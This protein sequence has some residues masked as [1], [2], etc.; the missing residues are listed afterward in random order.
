MPSEPT[1]Q[2]PRE[3]VVLGL[4]RLLP[5]PIHEDPLA[6]LSPCASQAREYREYAGDV[7]L[8][9]SVIAC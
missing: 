6:H 7:L 2:E 4:R 5:E 8:A 1:L 3:L 9:S